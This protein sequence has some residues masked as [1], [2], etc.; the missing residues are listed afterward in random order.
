MV[1]R[2]RRQPQVAIQLPPSFDRRERDLGIRQ[3]P[4]PNGGPRSI[5]CALLRAENWKIMFGDSLNDGSCNC[6]NRAATEFCKKQRTIARPA[7][8]GCLGT[9]PEPLVD[10]SASHGPAQLKH[11]RR[12]KQSHALSLTPDVRSLSDLPKISTWQRLCKQAPLCFK[13]FRA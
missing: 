13:G 2:S 6:R 8:D 4:R 5:H 10:A 1:A 7:M 9:T 3:V 11:P 12:Y